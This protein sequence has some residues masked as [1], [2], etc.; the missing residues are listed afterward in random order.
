MLTV[1]TSND[2]PLHTTAAVGRGRLSDIFH[3]YRRGLK[4]GGGGGGLID[5]MVGAFA[6][7]AGLEAKGGGAAEGARLEAAG[8]GATGLGLGTAMACTITGRENDGCC[9]NSFLTRCRHSS[10]PFRTK[11]L[12][13]R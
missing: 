4:G 12:W 8:W 1:W 2:W 3:T 9:K 6:E 10:I 11:F 5:R 7:G 13:M